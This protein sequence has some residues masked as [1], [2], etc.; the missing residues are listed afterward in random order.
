LF[1]E[2]RDKREESLKNCGAKMKMI[3]CRVKEDYFD[4]TK[5]LIESNIPIIQEYDFIDDK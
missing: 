4:V 3:K 5:L 1:P 2:E